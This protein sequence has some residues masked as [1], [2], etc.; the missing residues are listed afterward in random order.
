M[1]QLDKTKVKLT[2]I[3]ARA[4]IHGE[5]RR[6]AFDMMF[7]AKSS[8]DVLIPFH[9]ELR[10]MLYKENDSPD[11]IDQVEGGSLT[12]LRFPKMGAIKWD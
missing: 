10:A 4:E 12:A 1:F 2:S 7:E 6:P 9:P 3:N 11:L 8:N 5:D